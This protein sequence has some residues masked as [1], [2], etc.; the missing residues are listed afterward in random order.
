MTVSEAIIKWLKGFDAATKKMKSI[1]TDIQRENDYSY[2]LVR[3]PVQNV[4]AYLSGKRVYTDHYMIQ[5]RLPS[6]Y[7]PECVSN[8]TFGEAL[9]KWV[10]EQ[11]RAGN[12][13]LIE[14]ALVRD[15]SITTPFYAGKT[16]TENS[17]YEMT[18]AIKYEK[19]I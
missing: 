6:R 7:N 15:I 4:K 14:G 11:N 5:A 9:E 8:N 12:Y 16:S 17:I 19:E 13:P 18:I 3:E 1:D 2:S 10:R